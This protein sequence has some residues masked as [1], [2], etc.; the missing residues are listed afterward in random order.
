MQ[1]AR[2]VLDNKVI[3]HGSVFAHGNNCFGELI[4][5]TS[6]SGYEEVLTDPS[7]KN[8]FVL[9]TYP[10]IGNYGINENNVQS[11]APHLSGLIVHE[12]MSYPS[13]WESKQ[14]LKDYLEQHNIMGIEGIDTRHL[15]RSLRHKGAMNAYITA[16]SSLSDDELIQ[17]VLKYEGI[18]G[19]NL[20]KEVST[21]KPYSWTAPEKVKF[22]VAVIDCGVK[23]S[24][25][26]QL[27]SLGCQITVFPYNTP[28]AAIILKTALSTP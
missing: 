2:I 21:D 20:A 19:K 23:Y 12:Y 26:N 27:Q 15:T 4:F 25:L 9:M 11:S 24:I 7:Y 6:M 8:Q 18:T 16:D 5:N 10:L 3:Y 1:P 22:K 13:N 14:S 28:S 17:N